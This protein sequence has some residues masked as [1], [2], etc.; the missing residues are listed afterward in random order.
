MDLDVG[1]IHFICNLVSV[2]IEVPVSLNLL[3]SIANGAA[4]AGWIV[5]LATPFLPRIA[6]IVSGYAI[7]LALSAIYT[8]IAIAY[9]GGAE[10]GFDTLQNVALLFTQPE[11]VLL[12]WVHFLA[13]DL[14]I[15]AWEAR[16]ARAEAIPFLLV[17]PCLVFTFLLGP[18]GLLMFLALRAIRRAMAR[19]AVQ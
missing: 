12:G 10:G 18:V 6:N 9:F 19:R 16:T 17:I 2:K 15:G 5:L 13:F 4:L 14:F 11:M 8:G 7:P 3:F 1:K